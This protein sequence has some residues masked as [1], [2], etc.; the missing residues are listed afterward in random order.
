MTLA[1][2]FDGVI[3]E[4]TDQS[5]NNEVMFRAPVKGA[6]DFIRRRLAM[7]D[8]VYVY[9]VRADT[10]T[11]VRTIENYLMNIS[12]LSPTHVGALIITSRKPLADVYID[13]RAWRFEGA[14]PTQTQ[15]EKA[16]TNWMGQ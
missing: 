15:L 12:G 4:T 16:A 3:A 9:S 6:A 2:D 5:N 1:I 8:R 13:D 7:N 11:G 14:W 10:Y